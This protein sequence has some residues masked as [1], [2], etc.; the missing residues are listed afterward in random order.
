M[1]S[2]NSSYVYN[3]PHFPLILSFVILSNVL[4]SFIA[5]TGILRLLASNTGIEPSALCGIRRKS[6]SFIESPSVLLI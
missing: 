1:L 5:H 6:R 4:F 2:R 3:I